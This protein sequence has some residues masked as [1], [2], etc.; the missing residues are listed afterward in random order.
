M[1]SNY[2]FAW[3]GGRFRSPL[4]NPA[5]GRHRISRPM[6]IVAPIPKWTGMN[7]F[8]FLSFSYFGGLNL[9]VG[10]RNR[11]HKKCP[12]KVSSKSVHEKCQQTMS[13]KNFHKKCPQKVSTK[14]VHKKC[15]KKCPQKIL[16]K[17]FTKS[18]R[19]AEGE[20][21]GRGRW[22][23]GDPA[24]SPTMHSRMLLLIVT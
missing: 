24:N 10:G 12:Q 9:C 15:P 19:W 1:L 20:R 21:Q 8:F 13:T 5:Y 3:Q 18:K 16:Y 4:K 22:A 11:V 17:F 14:S 7:I 6:Q 23:P 2:Y